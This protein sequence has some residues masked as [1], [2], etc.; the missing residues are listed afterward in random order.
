[1]VII[2]FAPK[3]SRILPNLFCK[4]FKHCAVVVPNSNGF[5]LYQFI[6]RKHIEKIQIKPRDIKILGQ[7]G[8][9]FVYVPCAL[10]KPF[11]PK[12]LTCVNMAKYALG[13]RAPFIQTPRALYN[14]I[15]E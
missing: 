8:W 2:A 11:P 12:S 14:A 5:I 13:I 3:S 9:H 15:N 4:R 10:H 1:M 6:T 7:Y